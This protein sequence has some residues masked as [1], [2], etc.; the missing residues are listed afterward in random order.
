[1]MNKLVFLAVMSGIV[2]ALIVPSLASDKKEINNNK[3]DNRKDHEDKRKK[4]EE[5]FKEAR[6]EIADYVRD[7]KNEVKDTISEAVMSKIKEKFDKIDKDGGEP[8][9]SSTEESQSSESEEEKK[10]YT[11]IEA[12][13]AKEIESLAKDVKS[14]I[15]DRVMR[16][17]EFIKASV[18]EKLELIG[19]ALDKIR[20]EN[21]DDDGIEE[22]VENRRNVRTDQTIKK[23]TSNELEALIENV[24]DNEVNG[25]TE[26]KSTAN[27]D[28]V[29]LLLHKLLRNFQSDID[30]LKD[31][32]RSFV[33][34]EREMKE[35][36]KNLHGREIV[37]GKWRSTFSFEKLNS[38]K[39]SLREM[40]EKKKSFVVQKVELK[41]KIL[42]TLHNMSLVHLGRTGNAFSY[43][44]FLESVL[45]G[46][47]ELPRVLS[48]LFGDIKG[49]VQE[50][51]EEVA[52]EVVNP[53]TP[54]P[55]LEGETTAASVEV[56]TAEEES[57]EESSVVEIL[58]RVKQLESDLANRISALENEVK[59]KVQEQVQ[60]IR[61]VISNLVLETEV[62]DTPTDLLSNETSDG[63]VLRDVIDAAIN[64]MVT[65]NASEISLS[66]KD[67]LFDLLIENL[68]KEFDPS[69][70]K[71]RLWKQQF[72]R[73]RDALIDIADNLQKSVDE[74]VDVSKISIDLT[75]YTNLLREVHNVKALYLN[76]K[77]KV[78]SLVLAAF[79]RVSST[80]QNR[81]GDELNYA[82]IISSSESSSSS[83]TPLLGDFYSD[84]STVAKAEGLKFDA[85]EPDSPDSNV[86]EGSPS[87]IVGVAVVGTVVVVLAAFGIGFFAYR[88]HRRQRLYTQI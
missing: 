3:S 43:L 33:S 45:N 13:L 69:I 17:K 47:I 12:A 6:K 14:K 44:G 64:S 80:Y 56:T 2:L 11:K 54:A 10:R 81:T 50:L 82:E 29:C 58:D 23:E 27:A 48:D 19:K 18:Q 16:R 75:E 66:G 83:L 46:T 87:S 59:A 9:K 25:T 8:S 65:S 41:R 21:R 74:A 30:S 49:A 77:E 7:I 40:L 15:L 70:Q 4:V 22:R 26:P 79:E 73:I 1:M 61:E 28:V 42:S 72:Q 39:S 38:F 53:E 24:M 85:V 78:K 57:I 35:K 32:W 86:G 55:S 62:I 5:K 67:A 52:E 63:R 68:L 51:K 31:S 20:S 84:L 88:R 71:L 76:E 36:A 34:A 60:K 37:D